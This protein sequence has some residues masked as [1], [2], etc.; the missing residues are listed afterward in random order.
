MHMHPDLAPVWSSERPFV[1]E[2]QMGQGLLIQSTEENSEEKPKMTRA[3]DE[4]GWTNGNDS[5]HGIA[6]LTDTYMQFMI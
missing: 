1:V 6:A 2:G 3:E 5:F 4:A